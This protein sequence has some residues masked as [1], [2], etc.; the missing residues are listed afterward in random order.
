MIGQAGGM[1]LSKIGMQTDSGYLDAFSATQVRAIA[2][3]ICFI[4]FFTITKRWRDVRNALCDTRAVVFT[5]MGAVFGPFIG[6]SLSLLTL[7]Y[8]TTGV[9]ST[10]FAL[11]PITII[12]FSIFL[13]KEHV[14]IRAVI[15]ACTAVAGV[16]L[17]T[18]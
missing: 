7:H 11:V 15:G 2:A 18:I 13:Q 4:L 1:V 9:A 17:L 8:L 6:V 12:P 5:S 16:Y 3:F 10:F 14:S